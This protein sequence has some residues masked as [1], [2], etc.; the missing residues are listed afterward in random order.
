MRYRYQVPEAVMRVAGTL[1]E[2]A[3]NAAIASIRIKGGAVF[4]PAVI[5]YPNYLAA[6]EGYD[7]LPF[8]PEDIEAV[9]QTPDDLKKRSKSTWSWYIEKP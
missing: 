2:F 4:S 6:I 8:K 1:D 5:V 3:N 9:F 7:D